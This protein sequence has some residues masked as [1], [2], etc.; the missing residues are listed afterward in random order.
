MI[1]VSFRLLVQLKLLGVDQHQKQVFERAAP[2]APSA[3][4][5]IEKALDL[6]PL[7]FGGSTAVSPQIE[8]LDNSPVFTFPRQQLA[9]DVCLLLH[10]AAYRIAIHQMQRLRQRRTVAAP[11]HDIAPRKSERG[12][13]VWRTDGS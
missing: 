7:R 8:R 10:Q 12:Q 2:G 3:T 1:I 11:R 13:E 9:E 4:F 6:F 5:R